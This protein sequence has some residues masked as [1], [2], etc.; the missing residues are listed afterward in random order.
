LSVK[1]IRVQ[2]GDRI[3]VYS[4][5]PQ[6]PFA[7]IFNASRL[8]AFEHGFVNVTDPAVPGSLV[9]F[10][11]L[12]FPY[13]FSVAAYY[14]TAGQNGVFLIESYRLS[15]V[16]FKKKVYAQ[17][18]KYCHYIVYTL[19]DAKLCDTFSLQFC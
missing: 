4:Q 13:T 7:Y 12:A 9:E 16:L 18:N 19:K 17:F 3:G 2:P 6:S 14:Y 15:N 10:D 8:S 5:L 1:C 11:T